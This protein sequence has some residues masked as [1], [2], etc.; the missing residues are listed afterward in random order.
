M[1]RF[2]LRFVL[3][4]APLA[5][6]LALPAGAQE[7]WPEFRGPTA[8][9]HA[10][11]QKLP[12]EF[13]DDK[14]V[15]WKTA[16]HDKGWSS[17]VV[18]GSQIWVT[19]GLKDGKQL[20]AVAVD[21]DSGKIVHDIKV[22]DVEK[23][24]FCIEKNSYASP[25]PV[26]EAG[27]VYV[28]FGAHGTACLDSASG[29]I[30]WSRTDL[31]CNHH[32]GPASSPIVYQNLLILTFDGFDVQYVVALDKQTG[33]TVWKRD[34]N[35]AYDSDNGDIKKAYATPLVFE[36]EGK[37]QL[38]DPSAGSSIAYDPKT[39][40][41]LWRVKCGGMNVS[42]RPLFAHGKVYMNTADGGFR[43]FAVKPDGKGDVTNSHVAW[44]LTKGASR[45][46]SQIIVGDL[47]YM[48]NE[49]GVL[50]CVDTANGDVIWQERVGGTYTA[51]P[52][53]AGGKIYFCSEEGDVAVVAASRDYKVLGKNKLGDGFMAS[54]AVT[55][56][57]L[58]LRS[59]SHLYRIEAAK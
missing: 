17:P 22:F 25:T 7:N 8:D 34:R 28:H 18:W 13:G 40:E 46:S 52:I 37:A 14:L 54:P 49:Q 19:T 58:I 1:S 45:Y 24:Q 48:G 56:D 51:S 27:R 23:P 42:C 43:L 9:G 20:F 15:V 16:I 6:Y 11:S 39:G 50:T 32:R 2:A 41:E 47:L 59:K 29:K 38:I 55:G 30:L 4:V 12:V 21:R 31:Q 10:T 3:F 35:I 44:K 36:F 26:V 5:A 57:A 33:E 53:T